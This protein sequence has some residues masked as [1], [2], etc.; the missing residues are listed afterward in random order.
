MSSAGAAAA[1]SSAAPASSPI[2]AASVRTW[3][4]TLSLKELRAHLREV[5]A[6]VGMHAAATRLAKANL[7]VTVRLL[8]HKPMKASVVVPFGPQHVQAAKA[9]VRIVRVHSGSS[10]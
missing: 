2:D 5:T 3:L 10:G 7:P 1:A 9:T 8:S 4:S 6:M